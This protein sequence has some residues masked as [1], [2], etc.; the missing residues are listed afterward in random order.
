[1]GIIKIFQT[2]EIYKILKAQNIA[3]N[4]VKS[5]R[6][7][8][9]NADFLLDGKYIFRISDH[10]TDA[11][12]KLDR[13]RSVSFAPKVRSSGEIA[14]SDQ[15]YFYIIYDYIRGS[16]LWSVAQDLT[17][18]QKYDIGKDIAK[19]LTELHTIT[20]DHYDIGHYVPTIPDFKKS[21][22][23]GH[24]EYAGL[25]RDG[26][27]KTEL[28]PGSKIIINE[29]FDYINANIGA[30]EYHAGARL[31]HNDLHPKNIII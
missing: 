5:I 23:Y 11:L 16:D 8:G 1:M 24:I 2:D 13:V 30:L 6:G 31:L 3:V 14:T 27:L 18:E 28:K 29:A 10:E 7:D 25:L 17:Y 20:G 9:Q 22:K 19:F 4:D 21:W 12:M 15:K 26:L